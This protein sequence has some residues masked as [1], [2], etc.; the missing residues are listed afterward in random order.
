V[1]QD[2]GVGF[3]VERTLDHLWQGGGMGLISMRE[4]ARLLNAEWTIESRPG[5]G[6]R[7]FMAVPMEAW[8]KMK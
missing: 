4:R 8:S 7:V 5:Q 6:T 3:E 2:D 1:V